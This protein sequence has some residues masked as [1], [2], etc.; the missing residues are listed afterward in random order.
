VICKHR[1]DV[2]SVSAKIDKVFSA[3][4]RPKA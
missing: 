1:A 2:Q 4:P 3:A